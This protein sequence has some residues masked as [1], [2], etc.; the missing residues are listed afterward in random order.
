[1]AAPLYRLPA[2]GTVHP[3]RLAL[4]SGAGPHVGA[5]VR[6]YFPPPHALGVGGAAYAVRRNVA[7]RIESMTGLN[8]VEVN[9][10]VV[11]LYFPD[12]E[13]EATDTEAALMA[14]PRVQ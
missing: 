9:I 6:A 4:A 10:D 11:N 8:V 2:P 1:M 5:V 3:R 7:D 12:G 13:D 14:D